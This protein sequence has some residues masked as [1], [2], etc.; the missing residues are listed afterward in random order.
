M[1]KRSATDPRPVRK[2]RKAGVSYGVVEIDIDAPTASKAEDI[3]VWNVAASETTGRVSATRKNYKH[4]YKSPQEP[5]H[6]EPSTVED[7][8]TTV[9]P[10]PSESSPTK[11]TAKPKR[12]GIVKENDSVS[13][14]QISPTKLITERE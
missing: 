2:R 9:D 1:S 7:L 8:G 14:T 3:R 11:P 6:E 5:S 12:V 10:G 13:S 4:T